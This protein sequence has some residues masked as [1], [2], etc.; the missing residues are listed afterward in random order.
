M[1]ILSAVQDRTFRTN[2]SLIEDAR[3]ADTYAHLDRAMYRTV[4][5]GRAR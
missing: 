3:Q 1:Q 5:E 4:D 2:L